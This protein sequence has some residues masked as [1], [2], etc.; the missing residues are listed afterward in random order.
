MDVPHGVVASIVLCG[1]IG[2]AIQQQLDHF[3]VAAAGREH[4]RGPSVI[5]DG[6]HV[7][8][9]VDQQFQRAGVSVDGREHRRRFAA[10][11]ARVQIGAGSQQLL[12][13]RGLSVQGRV[14]QGGEALLVCRVHVRASVQQHPDHARLPVARRPHQRRARPQQLRR[15]RIGPGRQQRPH[16]QIALVPGG[17]QQRRAA[18]AVSGVHVGA[19]FHALLHCRRVPFFD[20]LDQISV[21]APQAGRGAQQHGRHGRA[22]CFQAQSHCIHLTARCV[23]P[24]LIIA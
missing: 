7:A 4:Q 12:H 14:H 10:L 20:R 13:R 6:V 5:L 22:E 23:L 8:A 17:I 9:G 24:A 18:F 15:V 3:K 19:V 21:D 16:R 2:A 1:R 11:F